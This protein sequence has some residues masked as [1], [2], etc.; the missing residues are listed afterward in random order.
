[1]KTTGK[2]SSREKRELR[3]QQETKRKR[4]RMIAAS[5]PALFFY[6]DELVLKASTVNRNWNISQ[7]AEQK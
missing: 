5:M 7:F 2:L 6:Y 1:M 4:N 3:Q